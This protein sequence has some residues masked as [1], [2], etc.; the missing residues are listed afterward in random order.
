MRELFF[1][2]KVAI[3]FQFMRNLTNNCLRLV[4]VKHRSERF[5]QYVII[6]KLNSTNVISNGHIVPRIHNILLYY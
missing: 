1:F 5:E 3:T 6:E 4:V 2:G